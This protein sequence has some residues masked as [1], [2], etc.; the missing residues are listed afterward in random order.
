MT[1]CHLGVWNMSVYYLLAALLML[2][3]TLVSI[4]I[5]RKQQYRNKDSTTNPTTV[6]HQIFANP[7]ILI[8]LLI[9]ITLVVLGLINYF[10]Y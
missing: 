7:M 4:L 10:R 8:Y 1:I 3:G 5:I 6:K 9:P 2:G